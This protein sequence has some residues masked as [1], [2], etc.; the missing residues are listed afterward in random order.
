MNESKLKHYLEISS[1]VAVLILAVIVITVFL[2]T[3]FGSNQSV[4]SQSGLRRGTNLTQ[5]AGYDYNSSPQTLIIALSSKCGYCHESIPFYNK[6]A[7][8]QSGIK[9]VRTVAVFPNKEEGISSYVQ[10]K[11]LKTNA[12][13]V[14][15]FRSL[16]IKST[17]T[18]ILVDK[19]GK[20]LDFWSGK[21]T[22]ET[23]QEVIKAISG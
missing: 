1:S 4:K 8:L 22:A 18:V 13:V 14:G 11:Q 16:N 10:E 6:L 3:Y 17:P 2:W 12:V 15:D 23:E 9:N 5:L 21:L 7:E 20:I 19:N